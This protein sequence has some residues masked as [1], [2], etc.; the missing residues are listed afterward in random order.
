MTAVPG[1]GR[2]FYSA[3]GIWCEEPAGISQFLL[4]ARRFHQA[5]VSRRQE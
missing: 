1:P 2:C 4:L 3:I 5:P